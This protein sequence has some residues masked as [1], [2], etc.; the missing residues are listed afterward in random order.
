MRLRKWGVGALAGAALALTALAPAANAANPLEMN[1]GLFGPRYDG[2]LPPCEAALGA[3]TAQF[4]EKES[5]FWNSALQITGY[6]RVRETTFRPW[7][8][9]NIPRRYCRARAMLNDASRAPWII[10]SSRTAVSPATVLA[11][12]GASP[13]STATGL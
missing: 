7:T 5:T 12:S 11:S 8:S 1:F 13:G 3:I 9:D 6:D 2:A 4:A 10:R